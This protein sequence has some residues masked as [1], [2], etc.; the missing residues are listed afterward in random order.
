MEFF[1]EAKVKWNDFLKSKIL[2]Y[3]KYRNYDYGS[4]SENYVSGISQFV[5][6]RI[7][8]EYSIINDIR[9]NYSS[10][11]V[12]KFIEEVYWRIYW[13][14]WLENRP[15]VWRNFIQKIQIN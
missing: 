13:K 12:N 2:L 5:S 15:N 3:E 6:H 11:N 7:L 1:N 4:E 10:K 8:L 14:G 9:K